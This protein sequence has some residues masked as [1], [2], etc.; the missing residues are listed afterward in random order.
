[1]KWECKYCEELLEIDKIC[2]HNIVITCS[3]CHAHYVWSWHKTSN[4]CWKIRSSLLLFDTNEIV[5]VAWLCPLHRAEAL[6]LSSI[7]KNRHQALKGMMSGGQKLTSG[8]R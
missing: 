5:E 7:K 2:Y 6:H 4:G 1:M 3:N 8:G